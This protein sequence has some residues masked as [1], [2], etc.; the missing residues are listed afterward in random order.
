MSRHSASTHGEFTLRLISALALAVVAIA[1]TWAG[2]WPFLALIILCVAVLSWEWTHMGATRDKTE[3]YAVGATATIG[4]LCVAAGQL[5]AAGAVF[6]VAIAICLALKRG[7]MAG[8]IA[9]IGIP[10]AAVMLLRADATFGFPAVI[11]LLISVWCTDIMAYV[12]GRLFRGPKLAPSISPGKTW[13]GCI[14][15]LVFPVALGYGFALWLGG[16]SAPKLALVSGLLSVA[17]QAGDL[18]ESAL[19]RAAG[20]KDAGKLIPGHGGLLD[21]LD[22]FLI[23]A[24]VAGLL[25]LLRDSAS[26]GHALLIWP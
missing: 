23:A 16:T 17:T 13:S 20:V 11:F 3:M 5:V 1:V 22:G 12:T 24:F 8:G 14:G 21:R 25:A 9:Y 2:P 10:A 7:H 19:K 6:A 4:T 15:G 26:P 18:A